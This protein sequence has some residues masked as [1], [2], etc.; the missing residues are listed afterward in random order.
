MTPAWRDSQGVLN[1]TDFSVLIDRVEGSVGDWPTSSSRR[2]DRVAGSTEFRVCSAYNNLYGVH[3]VCT[4]D[5]GH[6]MVVRIAQGRRSE[7]EKEIL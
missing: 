2:V 5:R 4:L 3:L 7:S 6:S 1:G